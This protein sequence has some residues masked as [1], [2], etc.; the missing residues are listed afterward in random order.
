MR[1]RRDPDG[2][3][4]PS[5]PGAALAAP[6]PTQTKTN[7]SPGSVHAGGGRTTNPE[8][9]LRLWWKQGWL[10][11]ALLA[12][13]TILAYWPCLHGGFV[14]DD[15]A[16]T[17][18]LE[19]LFQSVSGLGVI[20]TNLEALQQ[21]YPLS[22]TTFWL[23]YQLWGF[24]TTPY[25]VENI[26]L[27]VLAALLFWRLL[28]KLDVPGAA[29]AAGV[30]AL[31]PLMVESAAWITERKNVLSLV[32]YLAGL[33]CYAAF[34]RFWQPT[35]PGSAAPADSPEPLP[36]ERLDPGLARCAEEGSP[37]EAARFAGRWQNYGFAWLLFLAAY[38]AK[39]T[40]FSFPA[41]VLLI[42]W[43]KRGRL[44]WREDVLPSLPFWLVSV[45]LGL[46]TSWLER[47][48]VGARGPDWDLSF[49][50]RCLIAGHALWFYAGKLL[51]PAN[52]CFIYPRWQVDPRFMALWLWPGTAAGLV[53]ILWLARRRLG[54][55]PV[56]AVLFFIG[57][58]FPLL[59]FF[60]G[61]FMRYSFVSDHWAYLSSLGLIALGAA[62]VARLADHLHRQWF[63]YG[64]AA[65]VLPTLW[66]ATWRHS[67]LFTDSETLYRTTLELNPNADLAHN[68]LGLLL[69]QAGQLDEAIP[70]LEKAVELR[71][72]SAHAHNNL[73]NAFRVTG[74][75]R[76]AIEQYELS[77]KL[78]ADNANT[79]NNLALLLATSAEASVRNGPRAIELAQRARELTGGRN[80][81]V[82]ATLAAAFA[83]AGRFAEAVATSEQAIQ[84]AS[85]RPNSALVQALEAQLE[86]YRNG[87]PFRE[88]SRGAHPERSPDTS[89]R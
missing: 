8:S 75:P 50:Q 68:N 26:L 17:L 49:S 78:D 80:P 4:L 2:S 74:R 31:H 89:P 43:W 69:A 84:L 1:L 62:L 73:A 83:E 24:V 3:R 71:P 13:A 66:L 36:A 46:L 48:H 44:R 38:L 82:L 21:Y 28:K 18:K 77:L 79:V 27:H 55:G 6:R 42:G 19:R 16:W 7:A 67:R 58:L 11:A 88:P 51:W 29:F 81:L 5:S 10:P 72:S 12:I 32:L 85:S 35:K 57:T 76:Q 87:L 33:L 20:W 64:I 41:V 45:G 39:A 23:D 34:Q 14:W 61:Y 54:R 25:H 22:A 30:F 59:G 70:H 52:L 60:N 37:G 9:P 53:L 47:T 86:R 15:D 40:A 63:L 65:L 56:T